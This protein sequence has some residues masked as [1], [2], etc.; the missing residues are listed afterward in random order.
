MVASCT[1][2]S[3]GEK[4]GYLGGTGTL[5]VNGVTAPVAGTY[6]MHLSYVDGDSSRT[7]VI[8]VNGGTPF[9]LP[10]GG[11]NDNNWDTP[12]TVIVPV[13]LNAGTNTIEFGNPT[14][15]VYDIDK[16]AV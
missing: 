6:L 3:G 11:T 10:L 16:I 14:N 8:T 9:D 4:V 7:G 12:Q 13:Q 15:Y 1:G 5:T 2:C